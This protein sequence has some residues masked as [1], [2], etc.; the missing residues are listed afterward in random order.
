MKI[1]ILFI[2]YFFVCNSCCSAQNKQTIKI[3]EIWTP[4][5]VYENDQLVKDEA[6]KKIFSYTY[7]I[8]AKND[9]IS[10]YDL[11]YSTLNKTPPIIYILKKNKQTD[12]LNLIIQENKV[13]DSINIKFSDETKSIIIDNH[14][15]YFLN[16]DYYNELKKTVYSNANILD[17]VDLLD[18]ILGSYPYQFNHLTKVSS[19]KKYKGK[20]FKITKAKIWTVR[21][22]S[23]IIDIWDVNYEYDKNNVLTSVIKKSVENELG[24][25]K[26]LLS[27]KESRYKY[28]IYNNVES[29]YVD[30]DEIIFDVE[31]NTYNAFLSHFQVGLVKEK[32]SHLE[33]IFHKK[34]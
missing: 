14:D 1:N 22:Q 13:L 2:I 7:V 31:K 24:F 33:R 21:T 32:T 15:T 34:D 25:E 6:G 20:N 11:S 29:R 17:I 8:S 9:S 10:Y 5:K 12:E 26:K 16:S 19:N 30:N 27:K 18:D 23:D 28:K 4:L 3:K